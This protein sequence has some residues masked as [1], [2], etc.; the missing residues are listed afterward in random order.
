MK[1]I[2][3]LLKNWRES[4]NIKEFPLTIKDDMISELK[5]V[6][7]AKD[8]RD[9][10]NYVEEIA[11]I[12]IFAFNGIGLLNR[13]LVRTRMNATASLNNIEKYINNI[14]TRYR[15]QTLNMLNIIITMCE[16][17]VTKEKYDFKQV[18][19][20]KIKVISSRKQNENQRKYWEIHGASG[21]WEK[22]AD[23]SKETL[24][25]GNYGRCKI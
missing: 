13:E 22:Q 10:N 9:W 24:Y 21:K 19:L 15:I 25:V 17:L 4:R 12:S 23:Q 1:E 7:E 16:E 18:V 8:K 14:D 5:E 3:Q 6:I 11:D 20:E 2:E